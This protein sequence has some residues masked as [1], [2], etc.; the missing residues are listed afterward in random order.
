MPTTR[1]R[2]LD[3]AETVLRT[4]GY[5]HATTKEIARLAGFSEA[6]LYK[7]FAD[8]AAI[9]VAV[10]H[11][12]L[13]SPTGVLDAKAGQD[14]VEANITTMARAA[15]AFYLE[16]F[17]ISVSIFS[18]RSLRDA[19]TASLRK[20]GAGPDKPL[21]GITGYLAAE[22]DLGRVRADRDLDAAAALLLGGCFQRVFLCQFD[23]TPPTPGQLDAWASSYAVTLAA[24]V[25]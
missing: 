25:T 7:N 16:S 18:S 3:A 5:A 14:T 8:K 2:I 15:L 9:L 6:T 10:L 13:P 4:A 23:E 19:H 20:L 17:P 22:R 12:R 24:A 1:E 11:E 21:A